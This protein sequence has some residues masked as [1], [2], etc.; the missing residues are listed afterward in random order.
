VVED[1]LISYICTMPADIKNQLSN[2]YLSKIKN[3]ALKTS[4]ILKGT[5][6]G[7]HPSP[8]HGYSSEFAQFRN[9]TP[10]DD[11]KYFDWKAYAKNDRP[12]IRQFHD[13]TNTCVYIILDNS[14]SMEY[15]DHKK[16]SKLEYGSVIAASLAY[17]AYQQRDACSLIYGSSKP[18]TMIRPKNT[19]SNLKQ[20]FNVLE[21][22]PRGDISD[23]KT[24]FS[25]L[26]PRLK[27]GSMTYI[28]TDLWQDTQEIITGL[29]SIQF[30]AQSTT[31]IQVLNTREREFF[32]AKNIEL[33]DMENNSRLKASASHLKKEYL[34][35][36]LEHRNIIRRECSG[37][38]IKFIDIHPSLPYYQSMRKIL[39][40]GK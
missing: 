7:W 30:K 26:A 35:T 2:E 36:L 33:V 21:T 13:E 1:C 37:L 5:M 23:L 22:L 38:K 39:K 25:M 18:E 32:S 10:G 28:I 20:I 19:A 24:M 3:L 6:T 40:D 16:E 34:E 17:L 27:P 29:K 11:F 15:R 31:L 9:Y 4:L 8:Y 14:K 12:V